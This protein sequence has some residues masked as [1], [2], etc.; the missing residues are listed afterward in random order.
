MGFDS[1]GQWQ[2]GIRYWNSGF[3]PLC[4]A[5]SVSLPTGKRHALISVKIHSAH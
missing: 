5:K 4:Q 3:R 2:G 1:Q